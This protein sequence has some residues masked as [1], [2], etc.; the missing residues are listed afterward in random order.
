MKSLVLVLGAGASNE[1]NLP[2]GADLKARIAQC[3]DIRFEHGHQHS[4]SEHI[5]R[6]LKTIASA[7]DGGQGDISPLLDLCWRIRDAMPLAISID[8]FIDSHRQE[9]RIALC[10]KLAIAQC[11]LEAEA[12]SSLTIDRSN[13][14]NKI[15]FASVS[16]TWY[17]AFFQLL[18]ENCSI[19]QIAGRIATV[20]VIS[21]NYDRCFEHY[22]YYSLQ[23]YYAISA[24][25]AAKLVGGLEI[26]HPYGMVSQLPWMS[27][28]DSIEFGS[29]P[30]HLQLQQFAGRLRTFTEGTDPMTS[31]IEA[32]RSTVLTAHRIAFLG[33]A[34]HRINLDLLFPG[35]PRDT[36]V[37]TESVYATALS[38]SQSN[39]ASIAAEL[40]GKA[41][42]PRDRIFV[43]NDLTCAKLFS[44]F[45]RG[46]SLV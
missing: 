46:L 30:H 34:F 5:A 1:V 27:T 35:L 11:I 22:L 45:S 43:R 3:L 42:H 14:N 38:L 25:D 6:V 31:K 32:I 19:D 37:P 39:C 44:E 29:Q 40:A 9:P 7:S 24:G 23:N 36:Y 33:F 13:I 18:T 20:A 17:N 15:D 8:N 28:A 21:F 26:H 2:V 10:G 16:G 4:G 12:E 41:L